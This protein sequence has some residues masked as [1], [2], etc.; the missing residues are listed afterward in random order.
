MSY[1]LKTVTYEEWKAMICAQKVPREHF[2]FKCPICGTIQSAFDLI[3]FGAGT[4]FEEVEN[5][6]AFSCVGRFNGAG[7]Y[8]PKKKTFGC[9]WT[10]GGLLSLHTFEVSLEGETYPR[11]EPANWAQ[12]QAHM[13]VNLH[14]SLQY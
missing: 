3:H 1:K 13:I 5:Y 11:F 12:A 9:N 14:P 2:A 8:S 10:L 7:E 6:L 4:S